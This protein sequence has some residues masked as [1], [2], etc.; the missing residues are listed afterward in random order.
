[1]KTYTYKSNGTEGMLDVILSCTLI[2]MLMTALV[3]VD[4]GSGS[5][6]EKALPAMDLSSAK[7]NG[8]GEAETGRLTLSLKMEGEKLLC[9]VEDEAV[10][11]ENLPEKMMSLQGVAYVALRR[12]AGMTCGVEDKVI[13]AC[14]KAGIDQVAIMI[15]EVE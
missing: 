14:R 8:E 15:R 13:L 10:E 2:F 5:T 12:E 11:L 3:R 7:A 9:Y 4:Q 1:M 6:Q